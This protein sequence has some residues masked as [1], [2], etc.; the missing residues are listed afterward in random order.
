MVVTSGKKERKEE[1]ELT[2][3]LLSTRN[4]AWMLIDITL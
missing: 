4:L 2:K 3:S 1:E